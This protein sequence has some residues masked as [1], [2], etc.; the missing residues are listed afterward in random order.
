M[1]DTPMP[2]DSLDQLAATV[3][4]ERCVGLESQLSQIYTLLA[5]HFSTSTPVHAFL[6]D[7][8]EQEQAHADLLEVCWAALSRGH[9][10]AKYVR[11]LEDL[12]SLLGEHLRAVMTSLETIDSVDDALRLVIKL[13]SSDINQ[14]FLSVTKATDSAFIKKLG[15]FRNSV[16]KHMAYICQRIP[17]LAPS[18]TAACQ[19]LRDTICQPEGEDRYEPYFTTCAETAETLAGPHGTMK[20]KLVGADMAVAGTEH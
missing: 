14:V 11:P 5:T 8:A 13:E 3:F 15:V 4:V 7:L 2:M 18:A 9:W 20:E 6:T 17:Q 12:V 1:S 10:Q 16:A 19:K